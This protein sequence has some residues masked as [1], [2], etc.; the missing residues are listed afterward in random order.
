MVVSSILVIK[1]DL[2]IIKNLLSG[3]VLAY[4]ELFAGTILVNS[5]GDGIH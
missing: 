5:F 4:S 2:R 3:M 1:S